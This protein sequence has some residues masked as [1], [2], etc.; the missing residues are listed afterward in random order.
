MNDTHIRKEMLAAAPVADCEVEINV[1]D[2]TVYFNWFWP[3]GDTTLA[4]AVNVGKSDWLKLQKDDAVLRDYFDLLM[5]GAENSMLTTHHA[6]K[7]AQSVKRFLAKVKSM[8][9]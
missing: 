5:K 7:A 6:T 4:H 8:F 3:V 1:T 2:T 9:K